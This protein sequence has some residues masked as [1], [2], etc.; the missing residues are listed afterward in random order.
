MDPKT[1][2]LVD[3]DVLPSMARLRDDYERAP[4]ETI[5]RPGA[6]E[7]AML[8][9]DEVVTQQLVRPRRAILDAIDPAPLDTLTPFQGIE[10][11]R[12]PASPRQSRRA[13]PLVVA[14]CAGA[15]A[16]ALLVAGLALT[17]L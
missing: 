6:L 11:L 1:D 15:L 13:W 16:S 4:T 8:A 14:A 7:A 17:L 9:A 5:L 3:T 12:R 10:S 2:D